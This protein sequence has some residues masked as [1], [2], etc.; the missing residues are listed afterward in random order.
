MAGPIEN[1]DFP[2]LVEGENFVP[3]Y[4]RVFYTK[5][6]YNSRFRIYLSKLK[7]R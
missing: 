2:E 7:A 1:I 6:T 5:S 3:S 4:L